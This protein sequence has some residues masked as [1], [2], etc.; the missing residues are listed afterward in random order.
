[1]KIIKLLSLLAFALMLTRCGSTENT[2][3]SGQ[4]S[5]LEVVSILDSTQSKFIEYAKFTNSDLERS[6]NMTEYWLLK[7]PNVKSV[8]SLDDSYISILL[9]S[10]LKTTFYINAIDDNGNCIYRGGKGGSSNHPGNEFL[11][12]STEILSKNII[13]NKKVLLFE[14][15]T[16]GLALEPQIKIISDILDKSGLDLKV[17]VLRDEQCTFETFETF[18]DYGLVI[19][20]GH[21][22]MDNIQLGKDVD[23]SNVPKNDDAIIKELNSQLGSSN[24]DKV[25]KGKTELAKKIDI[26]LSKS[27]WVKSVQADES[28]THWITGKHIATLPQMP[29][30]IIFG[31][32]CHSGWI[33][34]SYTIPEKKGVDNN[35]VEFVIPASTQI[36][37][38]SIGKTFIDKN[39]I[40]Y[41]GYTRNAFNIGTRAIPAGT[42]R[43][44]ENNFSMNSEKTFITRLVKDKDS[45]KIVNL[46]SDNKTEYFMPASPNNG[47][48]GD[49]YFRHYGA[50][51]YS[52]YSCTNDFVDE[53]DGEKYKA[54]CIQNQNW[55]AENLR[56]NAPGSVFY[57]DK[58]ENAAKYGK[59]YDW[60]T[61]MQ[62]APANN[63][64]NSK[65]QGVCPK[66]WHVPSI[67]EW[68]QLLSFIGSS[69]TLRGNA[70]KSSTDWVSPS[71]GINSFG[72]SALPGGIYMPDGTTIKYFWMGER[73]MWWSTSMVPNST[74]RYY[75]FW[76]YNLSTDGL[77]SDTKKEDKMSCRCLKD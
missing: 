29:N 10:G 50:D 24:I 73:G 49:L 21:G 37:T 71:V 2:V 62:G 17:T 54:I 52:Y 69:T 38:N 22:M 51:D 20:D 5:L 70:L 58:P 16:K 76:L 6:I 18:K 36:F 25:N 8:Y 61:V 7:Q 63:N 66:G 14:V 64:A 23:L 48:L 60:T 56:F 1:M 47:A 43:Q 45:T 4:P 41:Y 12:N 9:K 53:R 32:M 59:M 31:N 15:D 26:N 28:L 46:E 11:N 44:V 40:S 35:N 27:D 57:E 39:L 68:G 3:I 74:N 77:T 42:S 65:V 34:T 55:M 13:D 72:F 19:I 67:S 75:H 30:T 33:L